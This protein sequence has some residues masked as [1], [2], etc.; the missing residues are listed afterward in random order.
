[1]ASAND[2]ENP[3][4]NPSREQL[5]TNF[6]YS[7]RLVAHVLGSPIKSESD[8]IR[9]KDPRFEVA[10]VLSTTMTTVTRDQVGRVL[11]NC[12]VLGRRIVL[13]PLTTDATRGDR[14]GD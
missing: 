3:D 5:G 13:E 1:M 10:S 6:A 14:R 12:I 8:L 11:F 9:S 7:T 4:D 2:V